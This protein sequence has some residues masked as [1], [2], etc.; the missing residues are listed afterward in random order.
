MRKNSIRTDSQTLKALLD[1]ALTD[2]INDCEMF[3]KGIDYYY[4]EE[5]TVEE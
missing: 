4:D 1:P 2:K 5:D 3:I